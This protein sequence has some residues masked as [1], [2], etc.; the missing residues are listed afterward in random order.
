MMEHYEYTLD[1]LMHGLD[2][3]KEETNMQY[4]FTDREF[5]AIE[6]AQKL[7]FKLTDDLEATIDEEACDPID[8]RDVVTKWFRHHKEEIELCQ[9]LIP[10]SMTYIMAIK[11]RYA[12]P[13]ALNR[14]STDKYNRKNR[15]N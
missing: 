4:T 10:D 15:D 1:D 2:S 9:V 5:K 11:D 8:M 3:D 6:A 14:L 12:L 13:C 7:Y